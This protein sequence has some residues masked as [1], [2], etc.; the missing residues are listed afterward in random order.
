LEKTLNQSKQIGDLGEDIAAY[1]LINNK[2]KIIKTNFHSLYGEI[3]IIAE[4]IIN[5]QIVFVEVKNYKKNSLV[6]PVE[7]ISKKKQ[8]KLFK[9]AKYYLC[10]FCKEDQAARFDLVVI[11]NNGVGLHLKNIIN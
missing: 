9:T 1:Y 5:Q 10:K 2:Y 8:T 11:E 7:A 6:H 4:D 3:D